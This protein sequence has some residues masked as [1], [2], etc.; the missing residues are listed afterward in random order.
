MQITEHVAQWLEPW[1]SDHETRISAWSICREGDFLIISVFEK[2]LK[3]IQRFECE[4]NWVDGTCG[5]VDGY[6][7]KVSQVHRDCASLV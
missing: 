3:T 2:C 4:L 6:S 7:N 1:L 5:A